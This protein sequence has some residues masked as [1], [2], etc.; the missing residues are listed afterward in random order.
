MKQQSRTYNQV[1]AIIVTDFFYCVSL[2]LYAH[3]YKYRYIDIWGEDIDRDNICIYICVFVWVLQR[4]TINRIQRFIYCLSIHQFIYLS[5][6]P[7]I[8]SSILLCSS[9]HHYLIDHLSIHPSIYVFMYVYMSLYHFH[10]FIHCLSIY[11]DV[12][13]G[14]GLCVVESEK[15]QQSAS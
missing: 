15:S 11:L 12:L 3:R 14:I 4:N 9:V 5:T 10:P 1:Y 8:H 2:S 7:S 13:E 6:S